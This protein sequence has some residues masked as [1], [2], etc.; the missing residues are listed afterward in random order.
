MQGVGSGVG[1]RTPAIGALDVT[2]GAIAAYACVLCGRAV[3]G[4][5]PA[6][7]DRMNTKTAVNSM[8]G[9]PVTGSAR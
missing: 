5:P 9:V 7:A 4:L 6:G 2:T 1:E 3:P 8:G